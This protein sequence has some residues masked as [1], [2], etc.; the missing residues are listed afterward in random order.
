MKVPPGWF[1]EMGIADW[2]DDADFRGDYGKDS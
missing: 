1:Y 2:A